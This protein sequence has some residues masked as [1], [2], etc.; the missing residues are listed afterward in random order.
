MIVTCE[1]CD[2]SFSLDDRLVKPTGSKVR[3]SKCAHVFKIFPP[4]SPLS[5]EPLK[6]EEIEGPKTVKAIEAE[7]STENVEKKLGSNLNADALSTAS[8]GGDEGALPEGLE[9]LFEEITSGKAEEK[10]IDPIIG[11]KIANLDDSGLSELDQ[12]LSPMDSGYPSETGDINPME[13]SEMKVSGAGES[14]SGLEF[15]DLDLG[16]DPETHTDEIPA[17]DLQ[18]GLDLDVDLE[19]GT[20]ITP[21]LKRPPEKGGE[22]DLSDLDLSELDLFFE[23]KGRAIPDASEKETPLVGMDLPSEND[24]GFQGDMV[25]DLADLELE[26]ESAGTDKGNLIQSEVPTSGEVDFGES[27]RLERDSEKRASIDDGID[28]DDLERM[29]QESSE[30]ELATVTA[31]ASLSMVETGSGNAGQ[32]IGAIPISGISD[33]APEVSGKGTARSDERVFKPT[34]KALKKG[35]SRVP[36]LLLILVLLIAAGAYVLTQ[37]GGLNIPFLDMLKPAPTDPTGSMHIQTSDFVTK[38]VENQKEG[39]LFVISGKVINQYP[40]PH[41]LIRVKADLFTKGQAISQTRTVSCGNVLTDVEL[42][43]LDMASILKRLENQSGDN[44]SNLKLEPGKSLP[45]MI[46]F[47]K[48]PEKLEEFALE[49]VG[50]SPAS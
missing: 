14:L 49:V 36:L 22:V 12:F 19:N 1:S 11:E 43:T 6:T 2:T 7:P 20:E 37:F 29:I 10:K 4:E 33:D 27:F 26:L 45:F 8:L 39:R 31:P 5:V 38:F 21:Q 47:S 35:K 40:N 24:T 50:S 13:S 16:L 3:C 25:F 17:D 42:T 46:V 34:P 41:G 18:L 44:K 15:E 30:D 23:G 28:L 48:L 9:S 32:T